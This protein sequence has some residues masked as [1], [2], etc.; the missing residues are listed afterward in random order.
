M[1][2]SSDRCN[3]NRSYID[4][5]TIPASSQFEFYADEICRLFHNCYCERTHSEVFFPAKLENITYGERSI[6]LGQS[7]VVIAGINK[8]QVSD[9]EVAPLYAVYMVS[10][11][12]HLAYEHTQYKARQGNIIVCDNSQILELEFLH[13]APLHK[14]VTIALNNEN[15][16]NREIRNRLLDPKRL[17]NHHL[18]PLLKM[19]MQQLAFSIKCNNYEEAFQLESYA[20]CL[21]FLLADDE[22]YSRTRVA[23]DENI[24][25]LLEME[26]GRHI[27]NPDLTLDYLSNTLKISKRRLREAFKLKQT[28]FTEYLREKRLHLGY[29]QLQSQ[30]FSQKSIA[31]IAFECGYSEHASFHRAFKQRFNLTPAEARCESK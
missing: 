3:F 27:S 21:F 11:D 24:L 29:R 28:T 5:S 15:Y 18:I 20:Q 12:V 2:K 17:A 22:E 26:I 14:T 16:L 23:K 19:T 10:G 9:L 31:E 13:S 30:S 1:N 4:L 25:H 8:S 7:P 6:S